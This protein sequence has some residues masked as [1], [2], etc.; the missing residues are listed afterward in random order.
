MRV[1]ADVCLRA[2]YAVRSSLRRVWLVPALLLLDLAACSPA[3]HRPQSAAS[4]DLSRYAGTWF[5]A[6]RI[7]TEFE[8]QRGR[9]CVDVTV[10]YSL[11]DRG[12]IDIVDACRNMAD[13][14]QEVRQEGWAWPDAHD[15]ARWRVTFRWPFYSDLWILGYD[16]AYHWSVVGSPSRRYLWILTR[17][18]APDSVGMEAARAIAAAQGY[19]VGRLV[20][21]ATP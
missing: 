5:E 11:A 10:S 16:D 3:E 2:T 1:S 7:P 21:A 19:D 14:G 13:G 4:V 6:A 9:H 20:Q 12:R 17:T 15:P 8:D 18:R